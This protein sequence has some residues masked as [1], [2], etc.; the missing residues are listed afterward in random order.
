MVFKDETGNYLDPD[1]HY[2]KEWSTNAD[3]KYTAHG[4][5]SVPVFPKVRSLKGSPPTPYIFDEIADY[6]DAAQA[7]RTVYEL[8]KATREINGSLGREFTFAE[9]LNTKEMCHRFVVG[10]DTTISGFTPHERF[11]VYKA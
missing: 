5:W 3:G 1:I 4:E 9:Y 11:G 10:I 7:I 8:P 2:V 6:H